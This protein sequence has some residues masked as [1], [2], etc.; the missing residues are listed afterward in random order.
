MDWNYWDTSAPAFHEALVNIEKNG[1][2]GI[3]APA[4]SN[5]RWGPRAGSEQLRNIDAFAEA[6]LGADD[7]N[8]L[9]VILTNWVP[10]RY[11]QN[12][13]WDGFAY[14]AVA[15]NDGA[16]AA[17]NSAFRRYVEKHYRAHWNELWA[18]VFQLIYADAPGV[19]ERDS[20]S[21]MGLTLRIPWSH[22][23]QLRALLKS[24]S[25]PS[26]PFTHLRSLLVLLEPSV[27]GNLSDF[28]AL[29]LSIECLEQVFW[30]E[31]VVIEQAAQRPLQQEA[32]AL[33]IQTIAARDRDLAVRLTKD[34]DQGHPPESVA[35]REPIFGL[36]PKDQ[37]LYQW[38]QAA[39]Y[40]ASLALH[41]ERFHQHLQASTPA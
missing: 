14:A 24:P 37:L 23:E 38:Q 9:G 33:L 17:R 13:I 27:L 5:Y 20:P 4:L 35:K 15:F 7:P 25:P 26:N 10:S 3:G 6:Y 41:P 2:R 30:R 18:E 22:D 1:S 34:W 40:S 16:P 19:R 28:Q 32:A 29:A 8:S 21:A 12:S 11:V 36:E 39:D 31:A